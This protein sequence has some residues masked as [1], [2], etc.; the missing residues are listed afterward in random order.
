MDYNLHRYKPSLP[1]TFLS[2]NLRSQQQSQSL[3]K[4]LQN[5]IMWFKKPAKSQPEHQSQQE[6]LTAEPKPQALSTVRT[7]AATF[8]KTR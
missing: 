7:I 5:H 1:T 8:P 4:I 6:Q 3:I 2:Q